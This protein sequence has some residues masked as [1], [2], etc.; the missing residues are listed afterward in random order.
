M[1]EAEKSFDAFLAYEGSDD[2]VLL[3]QGIVLPYAL[4][5]RAV[6]IARHRI[7]PW[8]QVACL[9]TFDDSMAF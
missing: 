9:Q 8:I 7:P 1:R 6:V 2:L 3:Q 5:M 4:P